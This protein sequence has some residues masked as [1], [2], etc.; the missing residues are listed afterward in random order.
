MPVEIHKYPFG[1]PHTE[2]IVYR[3]G[4]GFGKPPPVMLLPAWDVVESDTDPVHEE[5]NET[6]EETWVAF[7][8]WVRGYGAPCRVDWPATFG[9]PQSMPVVALRRMVR[10][11]L[12][13]TDS[14]EELSTLLDVAA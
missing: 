7:H 1:T 3:C 10:P 8:S 12:L 11:P 2:W 6:P 9:R 4:S 13:L 14:A 5:P